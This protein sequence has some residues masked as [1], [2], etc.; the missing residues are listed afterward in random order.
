MKPYMTTH[1]LLFNERTAKIFQLTDDIHIFFLHNCSFLRSQ[2]YV[3]TF[4]EVSVLI[5][6]ALLTPKEAAGTKATAGAA[7]KRVAR[8]SFMIELIQ[9]R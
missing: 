4:S 3:L 9:T 7:K 6:K 1:G 2:K 5:F 8:A